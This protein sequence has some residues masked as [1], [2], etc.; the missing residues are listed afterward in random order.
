M[1]PNPLLRFLDKRNGPI[2]RLSTR[3]FNTSYGDLFYSISELH[4]DLLIEESLKGA[5]SLSGAGWSRDRKESQE[6]SIV[7]AIERWAFL[8]Y[9]RECPKNIGNN[10][11]SSTNGFAAI[12][13]SLG[14]QKSY[15]N[16][17]FESFER[18]TL[19]EFWDHRRS[20]LFEVSISSDNQFIYELISEKKGSIKI[21]AYEY[22]NFNE[23]YPSYFKQKGSAF[24]IL[25]LFFRANVGVV[26]GSAC[27]ESLH[28]TQ[29]RALLEMFNHLSALES[30]E[31]GKIIPD[32]SI[33]DQ[34]LVGF[35]TSEKLTEEVKKAVEHCLRLHSTNKVSQV[36]FPQIKFSNLI[37]GPWDPDVFVSR[38]IVDGSVPLSEGDCGR[39]VI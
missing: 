10:F 18:Y 20:P 37:S 1:Q 14:F 15:Q 11:D 13:T 16:S 24:F 12:P 4:R 31:S 21:Y 28:K 9:S 6:K 7:E 39:F 3:H 29:E 2:V 36:R 35:G 22:D 25:A 27:G 26:P 19:C 23:A 30:I 34:R 5:L 33:L 8:K 32:D 17:L 38:V